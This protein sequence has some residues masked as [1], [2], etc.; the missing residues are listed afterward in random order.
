MSNK[1]DPLASFFKQAVSALDDVKET[2]LAG[3]Q[4][5]KASVDTQLLKRSRDKALARLG[6][7]LLEEHARGFA[8]PSSCDA[9]LKELEDLEGQIKKTKSESER[10]WKTAEGKDKPGA[11]PAQTAVDDDGDDDE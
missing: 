6:E 10:L 1:P 9:L 3:G 4:A 5:T 7:L 8:L 2:V 11:K